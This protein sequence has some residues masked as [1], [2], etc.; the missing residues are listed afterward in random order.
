MRTYDCPILLY[1]MQKGTDYPKNRGSLDKLLQE[2]SLSI[3]Y[4]NFELWIYKN[5]HTYMHI[6]MLY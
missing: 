5:V 2:R 3:K 4:E 6:K 1:I